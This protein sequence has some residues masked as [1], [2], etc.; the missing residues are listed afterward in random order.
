MEIP[1][2]LRPADPVVRRRLP[3][4]GD[5]PATA[6]DSP[7]TAIDKAA[8]AN[9]ADVQRYVQVLKTADPARLH[10]VEELRARIADG[11]YR[12][13]PEELADLILGDGAP[14]GGQP[15]PARGR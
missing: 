5:R 3:G 12:A 2:D 10:K 4:A 8:L 14:R 1:R 13:D 7:P 9:S 6:G 15:P 11:S